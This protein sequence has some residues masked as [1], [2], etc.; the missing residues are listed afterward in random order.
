MIFGGCVVWARIRSWL[1]RPPDGQLRPAARGAICSD[2]SF[3]S[4]SRAKY[5]YFFHHSATEEA[6]QSFMTTFSELEFIIWMFFSLF[7]PSI[8]DVYKKS[9]IFAISSSLSFLFFS[10]NIER[11]ALLRENCDQIVGKYLITK[12]ILEFFFVCETF[13]H[14]HRIKCVHL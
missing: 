1:Q 12:I 6:V 5:D 2:D 13:L 4:P 9:Q 8:W 7:F 10:L 3:F 11:T 14:W